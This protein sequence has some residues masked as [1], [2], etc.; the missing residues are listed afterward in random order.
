[1]I[2]G[3]GC[4]TKVKFV[5]LLP[6]TSIKLFHMTLIAMYSFAEAV[7]ATELRLFNPINDSV[8]QYYERNG[9]TYVKKGNYLFM[10]M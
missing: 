3:C 1:M 4:L 7:G 6:L 2:L 9:L 5:N 10:K 8:R